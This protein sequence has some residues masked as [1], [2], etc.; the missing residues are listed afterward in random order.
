MAIGTLKAGWRVFE[1]GRL[2]LDLNA[3]RK[4][5]RPE[6]GVAPKLEIELKNVEK[7]NLVPE[8]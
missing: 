6:E 3:A 4:K 2:T 5:R 8:I 7:A 1:H